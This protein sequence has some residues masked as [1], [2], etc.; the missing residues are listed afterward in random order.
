MNPIE[1]GVFTWNKADSGYEIVEIERS[2]LVHY[3]TSH[4]EK[5]AL[6]GGRCIVAKEHKQSPIPNMLENHPAL[7]TEFTELGLDE[8]RI[9]NFANKYGLLLPPHSLL[10]DR[11]DISSGTLKKARDYSENKGETLDFWVNQIMDMHSALYVWQL[12]V[13]KKVE[14]LQDIISHVPGNI[15]YYLEFPDYI[16]SFPF[17]KRQ[18][19]IRRDTL[20]FDALEKGDILLKAKF[21]TQLIINDHCKEFP[22]APYLI[23]D[24]DNRLEQRYRPSSLISLLWF[25]FF[26]YV[27]GEQKIKQCPICKKW[28][29]VSDNSSETRW[30]NRCPTCANRLRVQKASVKKRFLSGMSTDEIIKRTEKTDPEIIKGWISE[31]SES[32]NPPTKDA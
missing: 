11:E 26:R 12:F 7:F 18:I 23:F 20:A 24:K 19:E 30:T 22:V 2:E 16:K 32:H 27:T 17:H 31:I 15:E 25:Q 13:N 9:I 21:F 28:F 6:A 1:T 10:Y 8:G 29:N 14:S 3:V 5:Y 4:K